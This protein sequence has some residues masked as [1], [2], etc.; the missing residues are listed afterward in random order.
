MVAFIEPIPDEDIG[1][2]GSD[3][4]HPFGQSRRRGDATLT[5]RHRITE[6][7]HAE[8]QPRIFRGRYLALERPKRIRIASGVE[9]K[10]IDLVV[11]LHVHAVRMQDRAQYGRNGGNAIKDRSPRTNQAIEKLLNVGM[12]KNLDRNACS[13]KLQGLLLDAKMRT[14]LYIVIGQ[15]CHITIRITSARGGKVIQFQIKRTNFI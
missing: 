13:R 3:R 5:H 1:I 10:I 14:L 11:G 4:P 12:R 7:W 15:D 6:Q 8:L 2:G 9:N